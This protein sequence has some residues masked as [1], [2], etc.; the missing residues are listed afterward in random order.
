[1][2]LEDRGEITGRVG[3]Q[4]VEG[5]LGDGLEGRVGRGEHGEC[6]LGVQRVDQAGGVN[7]GDQGGQRRVVRRSG[8]HGI[9]SHALETAGAVCWHISAGRAEVVL[10]VRR[11]LFAASLSTGIPGHQDRVDDEDG[12]VGGLH[13]AADHAG[14][15]DH[16][17]VVFGAD[18]QLAALEARDGAGVDEVVGA[19]LAFD[20][21]HLED[22]GE[23]AGRIGKQRVEGLFGDGLERRVRRGKHGEGFG[24]VQRVDQAGGVNRGDQGGQ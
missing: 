1:M 6:L 18:L 23:I 12:G 4:R 11:G 22:R 2:H 10:G 16:H 19:H 14:V 5:L 7:R 8:G 15:V 20:H 9:R 3:E 17:R 21:V 24:R 13:V